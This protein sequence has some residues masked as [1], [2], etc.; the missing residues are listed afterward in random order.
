MKPY[1]EAIEAWKVEPGVGNVG[2]PE[3]MDLAMAYR[4]LSKALQGIPAETILLLD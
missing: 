3:L 2:R 4:C 1:A